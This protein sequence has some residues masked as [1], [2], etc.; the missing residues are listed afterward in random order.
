MRA[1][2]QRVSSAL[3]S[4]DGEIVGRCGRGLL[5]LAAVAVDSDESDAVKLADRIAGLR[6]F[7]D[8]QGKMNLSLAQLAPTSEPDVLAISQFTL[9]GNV[10]ESRRPSFI[11]SA[12]YERGERLFNLFLSELS[13]RVAG[14]ETGRFGASMEV[15]LVNDGP[16]TLIID[17]RDR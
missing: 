11:R 16:V 8:D 5:V 6:I 13:E 12:P 15:Q 1:V 4:I 17:T 14:V 10:W 3:V 7:N 9:Y 2:V